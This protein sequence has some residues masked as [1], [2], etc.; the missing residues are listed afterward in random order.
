[1]IETPLPTSAPVLRA[2]LLGA[3]NL[4]AGFPL[5]L[6]RLWRRS[7]GPVEVLA[8]CG[9]GRSYGAWSRF[10]YVRELP[11]ILGCGLWADL[12]E[13]RPLPTVALV[14]DVGNDL[15]YGASVAAVAGWVEA[16]L[17]RLASLR[18]TTVMTLLPVA[19]L[20][21]LRPW[22]YRAAHALLFPG[23]PATPLATL[24]AKA[25][26]LNERLVRIGS[27]R[28]VHLI[29][30]EASWY[31]IDPIHLQRSRQAKAWDRILS[32]WSLPA[33]GGGPGRRL[34]LPLLGTADARLCGVEVRTPQPARRL[35]DGSTLALY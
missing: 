20:D 34:R 25:H 10:F 24:L 22:Q 7:N 18:A 14:T 23:H 30:P 2:I 29:E 26:T 11:G 27:E 35:V 8:A 21:R 28:G 4:R 17:E 33:P 16:S 19:R 9:R 3:S 5:V 13:R 12:A 6:D 32:S 31:G 1:V 15:M